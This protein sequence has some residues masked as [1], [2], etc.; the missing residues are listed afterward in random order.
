MSRLG[1]LEAA[2]IPFALHSDFTM[3]PAKPLFNAWVAATRICENGEVMGADERASLDAAMR[4][5]TIDAARMLSREDEI[6]SITPGKLADLTVL[7]E[8][9]WEVGPEGLRDIPVV[10]T[11]FEGDSFD[12][13]TT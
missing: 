13:P 4:A 6:G 7:A 9:P 11:V 3:A 5:I 10:A 2:G 8:D 12:V 1:S